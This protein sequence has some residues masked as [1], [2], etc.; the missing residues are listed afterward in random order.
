MDDEYVQ[1]DDGRSEK[2]S[3]TGIMTAVTKKMK[4]YMV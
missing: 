3:H 4:E 2:Q 1:I